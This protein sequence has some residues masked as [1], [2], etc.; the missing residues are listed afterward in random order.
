MVG[1]NPSG[2]QAIVLAGGIGNRMREITDA[3]PKC[4]LPVAGVPVFWYPLNLLSRHHIT[5]VILVTST[6][7]VAEVKSL[8]HHDK[9]PKFAN[10]LNIDIVGTDLDDTGHVLLSL[11]DKIKNDFIVISGDFVADLSLQPL[12]NVYRASDA[13]FTCV[14]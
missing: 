11:K 2:F 9:L 13:W 7:T 14:A 4:L 12:L 6:K 8:L 5:D 10:S 3:I 1:Q